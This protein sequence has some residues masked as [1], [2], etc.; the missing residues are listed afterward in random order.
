M[1]GSCVGAC[2][3]PRHRGR[4]PRGVHPNVCLARCGRRRRRLAGQKD[5]GHWSPS[6]GGC[7]PLTCGSRRSDDLCGFLHGLYHRRGGGN[8]GSERHALHRN[9]R[10][11]LHWGSNFDGFHGGLWQAVGPHVREG[12]RA[13]SQKFNQRPARPGLPAPV[14]VVQHHRGR[15]RGLG[16]SHRG[17]RCLPDARMASGS[18]RGR[19]G[20]A[21]DHHP[22]QLFLWLGVVRGRICAQQPDAHSCGSTHW[23]VWCDSIHDHVRCNEPLPHGRLVLHTQGCFEKGDR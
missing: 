9:F 21:C 16:E 3:Y 1:R 10:R 17:R 18:R 13:P 4:L 19:R 7:L 14:C 2:C 23:V 20:H 15:H 22:A 5:G 8:G 11:N 12:N 6:V